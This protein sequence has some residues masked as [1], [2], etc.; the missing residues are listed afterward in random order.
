MPR[1]V[2][3]RTRS[4]ATRMRTEPEISPC[5]GIHMPRVAKMMA[6]TKL[7]M[8]RYFFIIMKVSEG[9][10]LTGSVQVPVFRRFHV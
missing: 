9:F 3:Q 8:E 10:L 6:E 2:A 1:K 5:G 4:W 7:A